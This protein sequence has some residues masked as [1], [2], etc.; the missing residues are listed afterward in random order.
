MESRLEGLTKHKEFISTRLAEIESTVKS[1][2]EVSKADGET[3]FLGSLPL[4]R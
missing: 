4:H 1:I 3:M 2:D